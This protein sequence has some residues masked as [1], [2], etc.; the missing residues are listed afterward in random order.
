MSSLLLAINVQTISMVWAN[1]TLANMYGC[2]LYVCVYRY[3]WMYGLMNV[4]SIYVYICMSYLCVYVCLYV[5]VCVY[6]CM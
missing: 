4:Y 6:V 3:G 1:L 2:I 5:C